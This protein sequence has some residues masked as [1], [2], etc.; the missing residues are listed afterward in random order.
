MGDK[1]VFARM[2]I[3]AEHPQFEEWVE[4]Q[5]DSFYI[6]NGWIKVDKLKDFP[7]TEGLF[8]FKLPEIWQF[9]FCFGN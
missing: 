8:C 5:Q 2:K 4:L 1:Y 6:E 9:V 7:T 3:E